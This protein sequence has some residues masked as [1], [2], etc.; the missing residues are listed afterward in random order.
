MFIL[1]IVFTIKTSQE[2]TDTH[3]QTHTHTHTHTGTLHIL[4]LPNPK[5]M[6][7]WMSI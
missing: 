5:S 6:S 3:T 2:N 4:K 7:Q 1:F